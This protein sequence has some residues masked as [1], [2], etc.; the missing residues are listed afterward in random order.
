MSILGSMER[1]LKVVMRN[2]Y[3]LIWEINKDYLNRYK[4]VIGVFKM[5][6]VGVELEVWVS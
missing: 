2:I 1:G 4:V 5:V 3:R 6:G